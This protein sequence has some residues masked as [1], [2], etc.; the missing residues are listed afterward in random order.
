MCRANLKNEYIRFKTQILKIPVNCITHSLIPGTKFF[1]SED[2]YTPT[3]KLFQDLPI[4]IDDDYMNKKVIKTT[5]RVG[6][7]DVRSALNINTD[8]E[9]VEGKLTTI[10]QRQPSELNSG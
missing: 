10:V 5:T 9:L 4:V 3:A 8:I 7:F 6:S 2:V 1:T